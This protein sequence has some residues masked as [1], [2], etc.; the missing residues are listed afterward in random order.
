MAS[1]VFISRN[2]AWLA[3]ERICSTFGVQCKPNLKVVLQPTPH[4]LH[5][6]PWWI[7]KGPL[8]FEP[9]LSIRSEGIGLFM[10]SVPPE[11]FADLH[12]AMTKG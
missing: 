3:V 10:K 1:L 2:T 12:P 11:V 7:G 4:T 8:R 6:R 9:E 5:M